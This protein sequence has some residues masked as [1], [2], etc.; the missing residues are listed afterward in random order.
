MRN[1]LP[2]VSVLALLLLI[3]CGDDTE[4]PRDESELA[5]SGS[6]ETRADDSGIGSLDPD[7]AE[8]SAALTAS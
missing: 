4:A 7:S 6:R 1:R 3:A 2:A 5:D 8:D